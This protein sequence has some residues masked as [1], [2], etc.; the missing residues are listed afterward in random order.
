MAGFR[1]TPPDTTKQRLTSVPAGQRL[2]VLVV[3]GEGFE[4]S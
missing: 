4:P 1:R 3:A 2:F